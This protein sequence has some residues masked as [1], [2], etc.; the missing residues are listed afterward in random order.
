MSSKI[1]QIAGFLEDD[2]DL[3]YL[4]ANAGFRT[5]AAIR[6][7]SDGQ[8][9]SIVNIDADRLKKIREGLPYLPASG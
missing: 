4:L 6:H 9:T 5:P 1:N 7:A 2:I 3:A 8:L